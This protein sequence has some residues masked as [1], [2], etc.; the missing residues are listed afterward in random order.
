MNH[1]VIAARNG[2]ELTTDGE[3]LWMEAERMLELDD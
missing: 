1:P 2:N 3:R